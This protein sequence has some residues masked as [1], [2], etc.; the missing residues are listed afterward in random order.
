[1][2]IKL[3]PLLTLSLA[4]MFVRLTTLSVFI[5]VL[6]I[7][8]NYRMFI[9]QDVIGLGGFEGMLRSEHGSC[10]GIM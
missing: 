1:M 9:E 5:V 6:I 2:S 8:L 10:S 3:K 4:T 7:V